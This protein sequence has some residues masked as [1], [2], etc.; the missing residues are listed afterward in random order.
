MSLAMTLASMGPTSGP[1]RSYL[2]RGLTSSSFGD[3]VSSGSFFVRQ[4]APV[5]TFEASESQLNSHIIENNSACH[6][7][8]PGALVQKDEMSRCMQRW[9]H[10]LPEKQRQVIARRY[11]LNGFSVDTLENVGSAIGLTR[12]RVRQ[13]QLDGLRQLRAILSREGITF[14][15]LGEYSERD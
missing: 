3:F 11:G 14:D 15:Q 4:I 9:L 1:L 5:E 7:R 6:V 10:E 2:K 13:I 8:E 12:E